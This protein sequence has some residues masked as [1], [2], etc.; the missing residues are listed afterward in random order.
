VPRIKLFVE[1]NDADRDVLL[2][3]LD[4]QEDQPFPTSDSH[5]R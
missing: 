4:L 2:F 1:W 3:V 5:V